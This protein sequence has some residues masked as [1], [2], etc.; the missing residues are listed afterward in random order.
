MKHSKVGQKGHKTAGT[1][2]D[3]EHVMAEVRSLRKLAAK[4]AQAKARRSVNA[5]SGPRQKVPRSKGMSGVSVPDLGSKDVALRQPFKEQLP[6][7]FTGTTGFTSNIF[8]VNPGDVNLFS[9]LAAVAKLYTYWRFSRLRICFVPEGSAFAANNQTG[10]TCL[11]FIQDWFGSSPSSMQIA[12]ARLPS[13]AGN[14]WVPSYLDVPRDLLKGWRYVRDC[15]GT[16]GADPRLYDFVASLSVQNTPN[17]SNIGYICFE[18]EV[19]FCQ[20]YVPNAASAIIATFQNKVLSALSN[21]AQ[22]IPS[23]VITQL[24]A[25]SAIYPANMLGQGMSIIGFSP[26]DLS[27]APG[28]YKVTTVVEVTATTILSIS[29]ALPNIPGVAYQA[30]PVATRGGSTYSTAVDNLSRVDV[31]IVPESVTAGLQ[32]ICPTINVS[33]TGTIQVT[34]T[35]IVVEQLG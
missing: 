2:Q 5:S 17:A 31:I 32:S 13:K 26:F 1:T 21:A 20:E 33:G 6:F 28:T 25:A 11:N 30:S 29:L 10:E 27:L 35:L 8:S 15:Q 18:G 22:T 9:R 16:A 3:W 23:G 34:S 7:Q 12:R 14:A 19:D 24:N 4:P